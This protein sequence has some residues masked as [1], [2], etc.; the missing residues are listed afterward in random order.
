VAEE[1]KYQLFLKAEDMFRKMKLQK[2]CAAERRRE[3]ISKTEK[4]A[5]EISKRNVK[6]KISVRMREKKKKSNRA[7]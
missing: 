3:E 4:A 7:K 6:M 2:L 5:Y 1:E